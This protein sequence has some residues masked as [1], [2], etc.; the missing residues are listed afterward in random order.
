MPFHAHNRL[1]IQ[2]AASVGTAFRPDD[3]GLTARSG[4]RTPLSLLIVVMQDRLLR[5]SGQFVF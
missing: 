3:L 2:D 5:R 1:A 4:L